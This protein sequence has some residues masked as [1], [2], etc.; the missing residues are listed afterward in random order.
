MS[1]WALTGLA[2]AAGAALGYFFG[3]DEGQH[4]GY[5][6]GYEHGARDAQDQERG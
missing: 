6:N 1:I 5:Q 2:F 3:R 4:A